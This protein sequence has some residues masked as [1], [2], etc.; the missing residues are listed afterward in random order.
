M[1][2]YSP[3]F[4]ICTLVVVI[5]A[6]AVS[7]AVREF[8]LRKAKSGGYLKI[9]DGDKFTYQI[10]ISALWILLTAG[11]L[12]RKLDSAASSRLWLERAASDD[13][14]RDHAS[15]FSDQLARDESLV[16]FYKIMLA[17]WCIILVWSVF[18]RF[19]YGGTHISQEGIFRGGTF[20]DREKIS[21]E[22][23]GDNFTI[24]IKKGKK[25]FDLK[26]KT[27]GSEERCEAG[28]LMDRYYTHHC[29]TADEP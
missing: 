12:K 10:V 22:S 14:Y 19:R 1:F 3:V 18:S 7:I 4:L 13:F 20:Y 26:I 2:L 25:T 21:Y 5:L 8:R 6:A 27:S 24:F 23:D 9:R 17:V 29:E 11:N 15:L 16:L 28:E